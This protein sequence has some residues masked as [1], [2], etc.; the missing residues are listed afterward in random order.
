M[1]TNI[2]TFN[3]L[4]GSILPT[5]FPSCVYDFNSSGLFSTNGQ[6]KAMWRRWE[7]ICYLN[8]GT[9]GMREAGEKYLPKEAGE[10]EAAYIVRRDKSVCYGVYRKTVNFLTGLPFLTKPNIE[11][12]PVELSYL[13]TD[14]DGM[15]TDFTT[16][17]KGV[18]KDLIDFG[19][20][21]IYVDYPE[22]PGNLSVRDQVDYGIRPYFCRVSPLNLINW[23]IERSLG[24]NILATVKIFEEYTYQDNYS[25]V[26]IKEVR[27]ISKDSITVNKSLKDGTKTAVT[28]PNTLGKIPLVSIQVQPKA[29]FWG[30]PVY[31]ELADLNIKHWQK[32]SDLDSVEHVACVPFLWI[33]GK[34]DNMDI[35]VIS[36]SQAYGS[37]DAEATASW[38]EINGAAIPSAQKSLSDLEVRMMAMGA[39]ALIPESYSTRQ[40]AAGELSD[41]KKSV[42]PLT[43]MVWQLEDAAIK[44]IKLCA[45]WLQLPE[46]STT[47]DMGDKLSLSVDPN[48]LNNLLQ[49]FDKGVLT[50]RGLE[51]EYKRRNVLSQTTK[52]RNPRKA[53][54]VTNNDT[55]RNSSAKTSIGAGTSSQSGAEETSGNSQTSETA[56]GSYT[57]ESSQPG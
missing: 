50:V 29:P 44:A 25:E 52:L 33:A 28:L 16:F 17:F 9:I 8:G 54:E 34:S 35:D 48:E 42:S 23:R 31:E 37:P 24:K 7:K 43:G 39:D 18:L 26:G 36:V 6:Y 40:T 55:G 20:A 30:E 4:P 21:H 14:C 12:L 53:K 15:G 11:G 49:I 57:R 45:E 47:V 41:D 51:N 22:N 10:K 19:I 32:A 5:L 1:S 3:Y 13:L 46:P 27:E 38:V 2:S 56:G